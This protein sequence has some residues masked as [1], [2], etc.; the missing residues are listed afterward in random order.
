MYTA[1][2]E[3]VY[4]SLIWDVRPSLQVIPDFIKGPIHTS[5]FAHHHTPGSLQLTTSIPAH[6][7]LWAIPIKT[8]LLT[9]TTPTRSEVRTQLCDI[10]LV[11]FSHCCLCYMQCLYIYIYYIYIYIYIYIYWDSH[12]LHNHLQIGA[13]ICAVPTTDTVVTGKVNCYNFMGHFQSVQTQSGRVQYCCLPGWIVVF[14]Q[15]VMW[16]YS[17]QAQFHCLNPTMNGIITYG[18]DILKNS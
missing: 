9:S 5:R 3:I 8:P 15:Q 11:D 18:N 4:H 13:G 10:I 6:L 12:Q 7:Y 2:T 14:I 16:L 17:K 1:L